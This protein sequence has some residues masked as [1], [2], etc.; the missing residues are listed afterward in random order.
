LQQRDVFALVIAVGVASVVAT[1]VFAQTRP[2]SQGIE[3]LSSTRESLVVTYEEGSTVVVQLEGT[4]RLPNGEGRAEVRRRAGVTEINVRL[5][6]MKPATLFGGD[7]STYLLWTLS[8]EGLAVNVGEFILD[9]ERGEL[10]VTSPLDMFGLFVTAEPHSL[11]QKP[12]RFVVLDNTDVGVRRGRTTTRSVQYQGFDGVYEFERESLLRLAAA[13]GTNRVDRQQAAIAIALAERAGAATYAPNELRAAVEASGRIAAAFTRGAGQ[14]E[15]S[16]L[17]HE[18]VRL[19][20][21]A[22]DI[23]VVRAAEAALEAERLATRGEIDALTLARQESDAAAARVQELRE[24][25]QREAAAAQAAA[26]RF[27]QLRDQADTQAERDRLAAEEARQAQQE[28]LSAQAAAEGA[29]Q[30]A[31]N[32][33]MA[34][35]EATRV[36]QLEQQAARALAEQAQL[37]T[38][39]LE[40][41]RAEAETD[42][43]R[44]RREAT[45]ARSR[46]ENAL[47]LVAD[48]QQTAR[49]II[50]NLSD[51]LFETGQA[52]L[53]PQA[54]EVLSRVAGVLLVAPAYALAI[55]GHTDSVGGDDY[56]Q[57]LSE[58]RASSVRD[59][60]AE[61]QVSPDLM[62]TT[63]YG[64]TRPVATNDTPD[65]RQRNRRVEVVVQNSDTQ[66]AE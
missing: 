46:M 18:T 56:N 59:Y 26:T 41:L 2:G 36:A 33:R 40:E 37:Q 12:S 16:L 8:P 4:S 48:T 43:E 47:G 25:A 9:G 1:D 10:R 7:F 3:T 58:R 5:D 54:R 34:A 66:G 11:V 61:A 19:A 21:A 23:A 17:A 42:A 27:A 50:V 31:L 6:K 49:G 53:R 15:I 32:A 35:E 57:Q 39:R 13:R 24:E 29:T 65:G 63:G 22:R 38:A 64:K 52:T 45:D 20:V 60:L 30:E 62:R 51:I 14:P 44:A 28:A 55:E